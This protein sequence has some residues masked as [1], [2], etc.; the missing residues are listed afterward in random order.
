MAIRS[1]SLFPPV[2]DPSSITSPRRMS[3][4]Y[5]FQS[6][7]DQAWVRADPRSRKHHLP[8][9]VLPGGFLIIFKNSFSEYTP[10][11]LVHKD[12]LEFVKLTILLIFTRRKFSTFSSQIRI[13][14]TGISYLVT[15]RSR[16]YYI[17]IL[18]YYKLRFTSLSI[19]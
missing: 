11:V 19:K 3:R 6:I 13:F 9:Q 14:Q 17:L 10:E 7:V 5:L 18:L 16:Y 15:Y 4:Y 8:R 1:R 2:L 12:F